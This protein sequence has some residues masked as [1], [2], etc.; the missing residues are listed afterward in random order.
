M[1]TTSSSSE[2]APNTKKNKKECLGWIE[3]LRGWFYVVYEMLFQRIMASHL[4]NPMPL[5]PVNDL[6]CIVTGSTSGI[7]LE[8]ARQLAQSGAHVVMAVRNTKA[9][10]ELIQKWQVDSEGLSIPLNVEVM[11]VDL[12]SLDSVTRFAEAWN[13]RSAPLH[14]LIN[15]AGIFSIGE[16]QKFSKDGY[17]QHLQVN[18]LAPALLS[19]LLLPSL[20]RGSPSRIVNVNS[21]MHHVGFV[22]TEDMNL[23]SGKRKFSS[24]VG[25][26]SSKLA[27]IMFSSTINKRL[28]AESGISVLCVSPGI[29]QTNVARDLPKLVQA[30]YHLIPYFIFSAQEGARSALF[31]ATDPQVPEYCEMLKADEWPVCAF[32]SQD[33]RPANPSEE[34]H[35]VQTSY[36][37]WEKTL[38]MIGLPS[39]AVERLL[40]G[41]E[42]KC[43][44][45][46]EQ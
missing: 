7:G 17:E 30:A 40:D 46:Q 14:V 33:C 35:N 28:P 42:V 20:I 29:V 43:R 36:E 27:E 21:I 4:H 6:T 1:A 3:W 31:A 32:I 34:A 45:G 37:V 44:Y 15:N 39:D 5:P 41:E 2:E 22:D 25:Y 38:E 13:A 16:P 26:S 23:T 18:H 8:I 11:Q 12:L 10:Q 19:I 9:A 24:M